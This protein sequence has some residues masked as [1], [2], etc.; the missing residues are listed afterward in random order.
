VAIVDDATKWV[1]IALLL[2]GGGG[3]AWVFKFQREDAGQTVS[4]ISQTIDS[5]K[6]L[7]DEYRITIDRLREEL[8]DCYSEQMR[9]RHG[10]R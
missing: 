9:L 7:N 1:P 2:L 8:A 5:M 4:Q 10:R 6:E 3:L